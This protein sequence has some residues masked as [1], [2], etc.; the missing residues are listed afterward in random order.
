MTWKNVAENLIV[1]ADSKAKINMKEDKHGL[2]EL[3]VNGLAL[4]T[5]Q[6]TDDIIIENVSDED[7]KIVGR[8]LQ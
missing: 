4:K 2:L 5:L 1:F 7:I 6:E 8:I 3:T